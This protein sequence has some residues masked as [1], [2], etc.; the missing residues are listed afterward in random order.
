MEQ[1]L[2]ITIATKSTS[3][4]VEIKQTT[5]ESE[6]KEVK[7]DK[8]LFQKAHDVD[9]SKLRMTDI[10][11]YS[12]T[13]WREANLISRW[14]AKYYQGDSAILK[15]ASDTLAITDATAN[16]GGNTLSFH[17]QGFAV[18]AVEQDKLTAEILKHNLEVYKFDSK[19]VRNC[20]YLAVYKD[21]VQ[22]VVFLDAPWGGP[23][24][25][26]IKNLSLFLGKTNVSDLSADLLE[27]KRATMVAL[28]VPFNFNL[29]EL[30]AKLKG[31]RIDVRPVYRGE[32][33]SYT[34]LFCMKA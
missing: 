16:V 10:G 12:V 14:I 2:T 9:L 29:P 32:R 26:K 7:A 25:K 20:D 30:K 4:K 34:M 28:K 15:M 1:S 5:L 27:N 23:N 3:L 18:N 24:Y 22:D 11:V 6:P 21:L 8:K 31:C 33:H 17:Q 13:P 19:N